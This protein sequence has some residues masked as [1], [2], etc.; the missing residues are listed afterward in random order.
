MM[1]VNMYGT[2]VVDKTDAFTLF[3]D[4]EGFVE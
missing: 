3:D 2:C 1:V 4:Y